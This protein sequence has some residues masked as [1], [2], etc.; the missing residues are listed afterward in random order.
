[1]PAGMVRPRASQVPP[2]G[3]AAIAAYRAAGWRITPGGR[4][5]SGTTTGPC[6]RCRQPTTRYGPHGHPLCPACRPAP[7]TTNGDPA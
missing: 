3:P 6:G 5:C 4:V 1:M 7:T 2:L